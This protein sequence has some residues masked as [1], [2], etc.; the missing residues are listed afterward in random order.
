MVVAM[1][2]GPPQDAFLGRGHGH[3]GDDELKHAAGFVGTMSEI[4]VVSGGNPEHAEGDQGHT[5]DEIGPVERDEEDSQ[6]EQ[7]HYGERRDADEGDAG[8]V[9]QRDRQRSCC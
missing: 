3:E 5:S 2:G 7:V 6:S 8:A 9:G 1:V 4:A